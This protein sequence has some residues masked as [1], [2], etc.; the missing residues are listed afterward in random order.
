[1]LPIDMKKQTAVISHRGLLSWTLCRILLIGTWSEV[2]MYESC[3][4]IYNIICK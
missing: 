1:M 2:H 4:Y 3:Y